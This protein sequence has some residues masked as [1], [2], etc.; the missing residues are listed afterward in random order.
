MWINEKRFNF[1]DLSSFNYY[2]INRQSFLYAIICCEMLNMSYIIHFIAKC[3]LFVKQ[4][5][6]LCTKMN[7]YGA[8][9][10]PACLD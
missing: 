10:L 1:L 7:M 4:Y 6:Y 3:F 9:Y 8:K 5:T 2:I